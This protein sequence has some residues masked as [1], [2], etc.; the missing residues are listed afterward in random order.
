MRDDVAARDTRERVRKRA[1]YFADGTGGWFLV[2]RSEVFAPRTL[3]AAMPMARAIVESTTPRALGLERETDDPEAATHELARVLA[4]GDAVVCR[5]ARRDRWMDES[6]MVDLVDLVDPEDAEPPVRPTHET[7]VGVEVRHEDGRGY[8]GARFTVELPGGESIQGE[9]DRGSAWRSGEIAADRVRVV[10]D[11]PIR[12]LRAVRVQSS[13]SPANAVQL[14]PDARTCDVPSGKWTRLVVPASVAHFAQLEDLHFGMARAIVLPT[15]GPGDTASPLEAIASAL[16]FGA[17]SDTP[18]AVLVAGHTDSTGRTDSNAALSE[19][20]AR[21]VELLLRMQKSA[22]A[23][24]ALGHYALEDLQHIYRWAA[25]RQLWPCDPGPPDN[26]PSAATTDAQRAFRSA[27][28]REM[29]GALSLDADVCVADWEAVFDLYA[30]ELTTLLGDL[31]D[32]GTLA[33]TLNFT[34]PPV[35][36][37]GALWPKDAVALPGYASAANR[38]V[39]IVFVDVVD[40][41]DTAAEPPGQEIYGTPRYRVVPIPPPRLLRLTRL[42]LR[43]VRGRPLPS[44]SYEVSEVAGAHAGTTDAGG[45]TEPFLVAT[46][47]NAKV[48]VQDAT[49]WITMSK[50]PAHGLALA[51]S[52]LNALG[53]HAGP[54]TGSMNRCTRAA[55]RNFQWATGLPITGELDEETEHALRSAGWS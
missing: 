21:N 28:N 16:A 24:H 11:A 5:I 54:T 44:T 23:E 26:L 18:L 38:R 14:E 45:F 7:W 29:G 55:L 12:S 32:P 50:E 52:V 9:L 34:D 8:P 22:W 41:P 17:T 48:V 4:T 47:E 2:Q 6:E 3:A 15:P 19:A 25:G 33:S 1:P 36:G 39:D 10:F 46:G 35:V 53:L 31:G 30:Q 49:Y 27:F 51:Q 37:C 43:D 42:Q 20:R 13:S 40:A